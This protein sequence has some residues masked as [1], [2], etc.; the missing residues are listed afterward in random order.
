MNSLIGT[1]VK[2]IAYKAINQLMAINSNCYEVFVLG[3]HRSG[4]S[5][6]TGMLSNYGLYMGKVLRKSAKHNQKG[7]QEG[8]ATNIN[9]RLLSL[10]NAS[11][12]IPKKL[13]YT[14]LSQQYAI[15]RFRIEML[16]NTQRSGGHCWGIKDPRMLFCLS[17]WAKPNT[18]FI[19]TFRHPHNVVSSLQA[20]HQ[21]QL[22]IN[23]QELWF[24]Y[25]YQL[26][27]LY[28][29]RPFPIVNFDWEPTR[30]KA[31]VKNVA[32]WLSLENQDEDFFENNLKHHQFTGEIQ[33]VKY[34]NLYAD[35]VGIAEAEEKKLAGIYGTT[36][37]FNEYTS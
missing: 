32:Q 33:E 7:H 30:Y 1:S 20:R 25:N 8:S 15:E 17:A 34:K 18:L 9:E 28:R 27:S 14:P 29:K 37:F 22:V 16:L 26:V 3:M 2:L 36:H 21:D 23:W 11:W 35:L 31:V 13:E 5:C 10:N 19:G 12:Y 4:T 24:E 6:L